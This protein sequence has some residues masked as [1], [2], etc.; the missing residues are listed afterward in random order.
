[1]PGVPAGKLREKTHTQ[2]KEKGSFEEEKDR[3][4]LKRL[5]G[6]QEQTNKQ[7]KGRAYSPP[8]KKKKNAH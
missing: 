3:L 4:L 2:G 5:H 6:L 7:R 1:M 8:P